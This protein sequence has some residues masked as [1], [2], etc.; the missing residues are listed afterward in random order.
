[1]KICFISNLYP[2]EIVGGA[3]LYVERVVKKLMEDKNNEIIVITTNQ[4]FSW[5]PRIEQKENIK[6]YRIWPLNLYSLTTK[7]KYPIFLKILWH[8]I[9]LWNP[10]I[11]FSIRKIIK[12]EK[13]EIVHTHN[14]AGLSFSVFPAIKK[15]I[16]K[17]I[18]TCHDY[19]LL[20]PY[21]NLVCP[22][23]GWKFKKFPPFFCRWYRK[24]TRIILKNKI[25]TVLTPSKFVIDVHLKNGFFTNSQRIIL[26]L[27]INKSN[28][29]LPFIIHHQF[30]ILCVSQ[31]AKHK[32][33]N[34][35]IEAFSLIN[36]S[37]LK[38]NNLQL[39]IIGDGSERKNLEKI[40]RGNKN[41]K[42]LGQLNHEEVQKKYQEADVVIIPSLAPET[43][44]LVM[45]EA[46]ANGKV[47]IAS[48]IG[49][50]VEY[51]KDGETGFLFEPGNVNQLKEILERVLH[52]PDLIKK[53]G[54]N[55]FQFAQD[56]TFQKHWEKLEE[57]YKKL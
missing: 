9:D 22:L 26:P 14:L 45:F 13:P 5:Q 15:S 2:P 43:F 23:T 17:I 27:G 38:T 3:E 21:A 35:L 10:F 11:Y 6:I 34:T 28:Q 48:K 49:A 39:I 50:L 4:K 37:Q 20:C 46:M 12:K 16:I 36:N 55:A 51:I 41:I 57:I 56:F 30:K 53:I 8:L 32:G 33:V 19:Y 1:M 54:Q 52:G 25:D 7:K 29:N 44:S 47:V 24:I 31:L 40:A 42:F 18:H